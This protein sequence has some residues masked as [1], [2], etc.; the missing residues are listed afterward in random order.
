MPIIAAELD[1]AASAELALTPTDM[2]ERRLHIGIEAR[3][4]GAAVAP[5][6]AERMADLHG[7]SEDVKQEQTAEFLRYI[8]RHEAGLRRSEPAAR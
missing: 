1:Y 4:H 2:L 6:T 7:W 5:L 8:T 3:D